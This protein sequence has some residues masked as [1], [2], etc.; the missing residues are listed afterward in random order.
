MLAA[1]RFGAWHPIDAAAEAA[2]DAP[3][4]LET[5]AD[6]VLDYPRGRSA[7]VLYAA[8]PA[9]LGLRAFLG[10]AD[11]AGAI[12]RARAAGAR[13]IRFGEAADPAAACARLVDRFVERFGAPPRAN[14]HAPDAGEMKHA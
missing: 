1:V 2:P 4:V 10:G 9:G 3:G 11:G 12:D 8:T 6:A 14:L 13:W 7:M 5:R